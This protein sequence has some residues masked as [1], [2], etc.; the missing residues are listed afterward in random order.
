MTLSAMPPL[1]GYVNVL[2]E[3]ARHEEK[4]NIATVIYEQAD[5]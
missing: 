2:Y 3:Y 4:N 5:T 1:T